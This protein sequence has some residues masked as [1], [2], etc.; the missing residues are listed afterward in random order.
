MRWTSAMLSAASAGDLALFV[1]LCMDPPTSL[2]GLQYTLS[3]VADAAGWTAEQLVNSNSDAIG[4]PPWMRSPDTILGPG[5]ALR[6]LWAVGAIVNT[7]DEGTCLHSAA[8][9]SLSRHHELQHR[10]WREQSTPLLGRVD[11]LRLG[12]C[13]RVT[14]RHGRGWSLRWLRP[15]ENRECERL[16][17]FGDFTCEIRHLGDLIARGHLPDLQ[18][19]IRVLE[20][21]HKLRNSLA[22]GIAVELTAV[23]TLER[24]INEAPPVRSSQG[25]ATIRASEDGS[26]LTPGQPIRH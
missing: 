18:P 9:V 4:C 13:E 23:E 19:W 11:A 7:V 3:A 6:R 14:M 26:A 21:A 8:L 25:S 22:H 1:E 15:T 10:I 16:A 5:P 17:E 12:L 20:T 24:R 2:R